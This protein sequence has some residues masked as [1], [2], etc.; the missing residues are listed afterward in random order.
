MTRP[1]ANLLFCLVMLFAPGCGRDAPRR[2]NVVLIVIDTLRADHCSAYGYA[3]ETTPN[4]EALAA[5][6]ILFENAWSQAPWTCPSLVSLLTGRYVLA[7]Y[8]TVPP[9]IPTL[10]ERFKKEGY[11]TAA[12]VANPVLFDTSGFER[13]FDFYDAATEKNHDTTKPADVF[14]A[15][16]E[17][18]IAERLEEPFFAWFH[19]FD[20]HEPYDPPPE[21]IEPFSGNRPGVALEDYRTRQPAHADKVVD[22]QDLNALEAE[23]TRYDGEIACADRATGKII[24]ALKK[25]GWLD[26]TLVVVTSDH[27]EG[28]FSHARYPGTKRKGDN[29]YGLYR[30]HG[31]Q[32][33]EE[34][35]HVPLVIRGPGFTGGTRFAGLVELLD[36]YP[37]LLAA[38]GLPE[39]PGA[40]GGDLA[41]R[42]GEGKPAIFA[43]GARNHAVRTRG[44][45]KLIHPVRPAPSDN[46]RVKR[47]LLVDKHKMLVPRLF[48]LKIDPEELSNLPLKDSAAF[49]TLKKRLHQW[50]DRFM[51]DLE[52]GDLPS[53]EVR[54]RLQA[55]GYLR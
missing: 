30:G 49:E 48:D 44:G 1:A 37:T 31:A 51:N 6:G 7:N 47:H 19:L 15:E 23:V 38:A 11:A 28:L 46:R 45:L 29:A 12:L 50:Q 32:V 39:D 33:F 26:R 4:L 2:I 53:S 5:E 18:L 21:F 34:A 40:R 8:A 24:E 22:E 41:K 55:L 35:L 20:P 54:R 13:G 42:E 14:A 36:L 10:S 52:D 16:A 43:F 3:R 27:G 9:G 17:A 25:R